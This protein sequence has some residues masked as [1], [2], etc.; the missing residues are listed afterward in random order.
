MEQ[1]DLGTTAN[2]KFKYVVDF[3][4]YIIKDFVSWL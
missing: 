3:K 4:L 1:F 2:R